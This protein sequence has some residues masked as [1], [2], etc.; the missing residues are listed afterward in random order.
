MFWTYGYE[1][2]KNGEVMYEGRCGQVWVLG[3]G[4]LNTKKGLVH[5]FEFEVEKSDTLEATDPEKPA[6]AP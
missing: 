4:F 2:S 5:A 6:I 1:V 3:C